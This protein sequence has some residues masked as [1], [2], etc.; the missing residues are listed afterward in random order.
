MNVL[1]L[2]DGKSSGMT[3]CELAGIKVD[4]YYA[5]E[6]DK[7]AT[8]VSHAMYPNIIRLGDITKWRSG[9]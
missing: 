8:K 6:I 2:F 7:F 3:A 1:S 9:S 4:N 5:S